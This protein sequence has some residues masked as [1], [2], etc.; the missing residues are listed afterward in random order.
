MCRPKSALLANIV[1]I[2]GSKAGAA[3]QKRG[4]R[5]D[6]S[7]TQQKRSRTESGQAQAHT[8]PAPLL[9][10][11]AGQQKQLEMRQEQAQAAKHQDTSD[12]EPALAGLLGK[13]AGFWTVQFL[14]CLSTCMTERCPCPQSPAFALACCC[15]T[16][17]RHKSGAHGQPQHTSVLPYTG[18]SL[19]QEMMAVYMANHGDNM[20]LQVT[21][22]ARK[23]MMM[24]M[25]PWQ[26][27]EHSS[28]RRL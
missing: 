16:M 17:V 12:A 22:I 1:R 19:L 25:A 5:E 27:R 20:L 13:L 26:E 23:G 10:G 9:N 14:L 18:A 28:Q 3:P 7:S 24:L 21:M 15:C 2:K 6:T 8:Q 4:P 11:T